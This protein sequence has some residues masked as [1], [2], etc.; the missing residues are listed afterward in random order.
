MKAA[1]D[2][3]MLDRLHGDKSGPVDS[4]CPL[5]GPTKQGASARRKVLRTWSLDSGVIT[6]CCQR[7]DAQ[8]HV[9]AEGA[10]VRRASPP[11]P[12]E[13][14]RTPERQRDKGRWLWRTSTP[15]R[16]TIAE[17]YLREA[18]GITCPLPA[19]VRFLA[20]HRPAHHPAMVVPFGIPDEPE[21]G[22]LRISETQIA[23]VQLTLLRADGLGKAEV[24]PNKLTIGSPSGM[25]M[26]LAPLNDLMGLAVSEGVEDALSA[27]AALGLGA[28]ASGGAA[29]L[30]KLAPAVEAALADCVTI[31]VDDDE[32][33]RGGSYALASE[34]ARVGVEVLLEEAGR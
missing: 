12:V 27:H 33:G 22:V 30:P 26:V 16:G 14:D 19:T 25:P 18:R 6:F 11:R 8:G 23:A 13:P 17:V 32:N 2:F 10:T 9:R 24:E 31:F 7:C 20:P 1:L 34:L 5:C 29:N 4:P 3:E 21:P 28:W 15:A